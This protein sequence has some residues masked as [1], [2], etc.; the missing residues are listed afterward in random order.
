MP[1]ARVRLLVCRGSQLCKQITLRS[2]EKQTLS[3]PGL[4]L[5]TRG[6]EAPP[7]DDMNREMEDYLSTRQSLAAAHMSIFTQAQMAQPQE[8]WLFA[9]LLPVN[10]S[11]IL[12]NILP[13]K[14]LWKVPAGGCQRVV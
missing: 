6:L 12:Q 10:E 4:C 8:N 1:N 13:A 14:G 9:A 3:F 2:E 11:W 5:G 7:R